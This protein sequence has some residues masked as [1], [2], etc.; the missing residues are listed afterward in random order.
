LRTQFYPRPSTLDVFHSIFHLLYY[1]IP[2]SQ[3]P[4]LGL[5]PLRPSSLLLMDFQVSIWKQGQDNRKEWRQE[6]QLHINWITG[7]T[8]LDS[9]YNFG[10]LLKGS[11]YVRKRQFWQEIGFYVIDFVKKFL[12][13]RSV[14]PLCWNWC[15][16]VDCHLIYSSTN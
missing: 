8:V 5:R 11:G 12:A 14:F 10:E 2:F 4:F 9:L 13:L 6:K 7:G 3:K 15:Q 16:R 1:P